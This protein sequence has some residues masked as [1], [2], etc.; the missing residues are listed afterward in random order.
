[1]KPIKSKDGT[2]EFLWNVEPHVKLPFIAAEEDTGPIVK[3]LVANEEAEKNIIAYREYLSGQELAL[4]FEKA[5]GLKAKSVNLPRGSF[6]VPLP[7]ELKAFGE[8]GY[9]SWEDLSIIH[10]QDLKSPPSLDTVENY[11]KKQDL[12]MIFRT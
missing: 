1:M 3:E 12:S 8:F 10:P 7:D 5:T 4:C 6:S 9:E 2:V 11:F